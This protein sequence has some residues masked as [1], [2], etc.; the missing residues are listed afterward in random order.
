LEVCL[1]HHIEIDDSEGSNTGGSEI[2]TRWR[3]KPTRSDAKNTRGFQAFLALQT[4]SRQGKM[5]GIT[6]D[7]P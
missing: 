5:A 4:K 1:I 7:L 2:K 6:L 3:T